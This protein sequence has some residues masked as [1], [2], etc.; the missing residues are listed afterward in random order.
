MFEYA[1]V[2]RFLTCRRDRSTPI[3]EQFAY[4]RGER[5]ASLKLPYSIDLLTAV[6]F[7]AALEKITHTGMYL[8]TRATRNLGR[9]PF[10]RRPADTGSL[11]SCGGYC[12]YNHLHSPG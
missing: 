3:R 2:L 9:P 5:L 1:D 4:P 11:R 6:Y 7:Y 10:T 12:H 8:V